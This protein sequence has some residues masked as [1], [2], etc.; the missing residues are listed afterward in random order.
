MNS[1]PKNI[2]I[3]GPI[4]S[5]KTL[6][7]RALNMHPRIS[8][9]QE[10]FFF[11]F[12]LCRNIFSR[13]VLGNSFDPNQP[14]GTGFCE[15]SDSKRLFA[16]EFSRLSFNEADIEELKKLTIWQQETAGSERAPEIIPLV[17]RLKPGSTVD[18]LRDLIDILAMSYGGDGG[19]DVDYSGFTEAWCDEFISLLFSLDKLK[20][21][22][23]HAIRDPRAIIASRNAGRNLQ[24]YGD[25]YPLLFLIR[26]W[27]KS[28]AYSIMNKDNPDYLMVRYE[29]LVNSPREWFEKICDHLGVQFSENLMHPEKYVNG[30]G[31]LWKQNTSYAPG[32]GFSR[33]SLEKW[34]E[35]LPDDVTAMIEYLCEAEMSYLGYKPIKGKAKLSQIASFK[36]NEEEIIDW[37]KKYNLTVNEHEIQLELVRDYLLNE[38]NLLNAEI[39]NLFFISEKVHDTLTAQ[40]PTGDASERSC[41]Q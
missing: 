39:K 4:R 36:E 30:S 7:G 10:P 35:L 34:K 20:F 22:C 21:K 16:R 5:G 13:D 33:E 19:D 12:K 1:N 9:Q 26:H 18:V 15:P 40:S 2:I 25:K 31:E 24:K 6:I 41:L 23:V 3:F 38:T 14:I 11:F 27:R 29:D 28:V 8:V 17:D 37:L 32:S